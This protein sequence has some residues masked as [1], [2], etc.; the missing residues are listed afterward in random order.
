[1]PEVCLG[2]VEVLRVRCWSQV[3]DRFVDGTTYPQDDGAADL[4]TPHGVEQR[5]PRP[6]RVTEMEV[7]EGECVRTYT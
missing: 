2:T 5:P 7:R 6:L 3:L 1:M 4:W